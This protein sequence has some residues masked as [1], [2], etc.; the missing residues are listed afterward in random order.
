VNQNNTTTLEFGA[1]SD[2]FDDEIITP[3]LNNIGTTSSLD[4]AYDPANF[5]K[6]D[7]Y[8][9]APANTTL[10]V[11]YYIG[12][13]VESNVESNTLNTISTIEYGDGSEYLE[14]EDL[15]M[16]E[17]IKTSV[18]VNNPEPALGG[19]S[20]ETDEEIRM[21]GLA[22]FSTQN[23]AVTRDDY[24]VR[25]YAMPNKFGSVAKAYVTKDGILDSQTQL[26]LVKLVANDDVK[27]TPNGMNTVYGELNNP[28]AINMYVLSYNNDKQ[29]I[30]PNELV[31]KNL[32]SYLGGY[33]LLTDGLNITNAFV[34]NVG[35]NFEISTMANQNKKDVVFRAMSVVT[36]FFEISKWSIGQPIEI[37]ALELELAKVSGVMSVID[38]EIVNLNVDDGDYSVNEYNMETATV[39][40]TIYPSMDPSIFELKYPTKD[41]VG[42][43]V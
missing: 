38:L 40:K 17:T 20:T 28:F 25:A 16:L 10:T 41:I 8:G 36:D 6:S 22:S 42:R 29:L 13:G 32:K 31:L 27:I 3:N 18:N 23:R 30:R 14:A 39:G 19:K 43:A 12:G 7:S 9:S 26:D 15:V 5:L 4:M 34:I 24:I 35:V 21:N 11:S 2:K 37:G 1:G 33:R